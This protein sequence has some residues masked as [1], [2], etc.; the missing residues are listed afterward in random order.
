MKAGI[1]TCQGRARLESNRLVRGGDN[2]QDGRERETNHPQETQV[3]GKNEQN[4]SEPSTAASFD[5][6]RS[7]AFC[8]LLE[9]DSKT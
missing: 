3:E 1:S 7:S 9:S 8:L 6:R 4:G 5:G 2:G